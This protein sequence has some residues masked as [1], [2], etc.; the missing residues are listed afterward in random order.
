MKKKMTEFDD[1][2][3]SKLSKKQL[4]KHKRKHKEMMKK[5]ILKKF[6]AKNRWV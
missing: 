2:E 1:N 5:K 3:L 4:M 6:K